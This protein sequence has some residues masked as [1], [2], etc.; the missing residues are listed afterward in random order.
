VNSISFITTCKSRLEHLKVT[1][2]LLVGQR[3][4]E[5]IVV[6]YACPQGTTDWVKA[7]HPEVKIVLVDDDPGF[8]LS[9]ARNFGARQSN[10]EWLFFIDA[11]IQVAPGLV[12]WLNEHLD[13]RFH[14]RESPEKGPGRGTWGSFACSR[15]I[16]E[17][18]GGYD[19]LYTGWG[20]EDTDLYRRLRL[21]GNPTAYYPDH[22]IEAIAHS[23]ELRMQHYTS[24]NK[25]Q[26]LLTSR[27][28]QQVKHQVMLFADFAGEMPLHTRQQLRKMVEQAISQWQASGGERPATIEFGLDAVYRRMPGRWQLNRQAKLRFTLQPQDISFPQSP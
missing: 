11:D 23:D 12:D 22:F 1:L 4:D 26:Q 7:H 15:A 6:D 10:N 2:P 8:N 3:P 27:F 28:Y 19:E 17:H 9:R 24:K 21:M 25:Q 14:Y 18:C 5:I 16:F 13:P 20:G